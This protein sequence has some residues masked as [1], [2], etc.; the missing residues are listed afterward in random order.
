MLKLVAKSNGLKRTAD[1]AREHSRRAQE[2]LDVLPDSPAK[3][4][5]SRLNQQVIKRVK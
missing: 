1:L 4:A 3:E 2:A 5:L